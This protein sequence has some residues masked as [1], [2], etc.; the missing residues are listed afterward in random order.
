MNFLD[1]YFKY[2]IGTEISGLTHELNVFYV[3]KLCEK[4]DRNIIVLTSSLFEANKIYDSLVKIH[5]N[6]LLFPMDDFLSSMIVASSPELKYKRLETLDK[7]KSDKK[8]IIVTNLMGYLKYLPSANIKN[9]IDIKQNDVIKRDILAEEINKLGYHRES[10][11]TMSGEYAVRGFILDLYPIDYEHPIRI[12]FDGNIIDNIKYFNENTQMSTEET[13][14]IKIKAIDEMPSDDKNSLFDYAKNPLVVYVDKSQIE[15]TYTHLYDDIIEYK[16][17]KDIKEDLMY[18]LDDIKDNDKIFINLFSTDGI[19]LK[20]QSIINY[21]ENFL[22]LE[23]D[24]N[25]WIKEGKIVYFYLSNNNEK[26]QLLKIIPSAHIIMKELEHGFILDKYVIISENDIE[27]V[28]VTHG[29]YKNNF[30]VGKKIKD[31]NQLEKGD[32]VVHI[33]HG[34]GIYQGITTLSVRGVQ[35]DFLTIYYEGTDKI[36]VPVEKIDLI[37]KYTCKDGVKPKLNK[38]GSTNW[39]KTKKYISEKVKDISRE[40]ILLYKKRLELKKKPYKDY[41]EEE[42][43]ASEFKYKLT[44][45]QKK[46][47]VEIN[48]DLKKDNPMDRLLCGDV[49]FGKT[50]VAMRAM[51]KAV[52]NNEQ[53]L[54]LCPTTILSKQQYNVAKE[55]FKNWPIEIALLNRHVSARETHRILEDL[56]KGKI[57]IL[58]GTHRILSDDI[59]CKNLGMLVV[60]EEQRFGV[61]HKEKIKTMKSD[62]N[63]LTLSATPIPRTLKMAMSGLR[64]LSVIDTPPVNRYPV[65]TYVAVEDDF[66][67][68]DAIYKELARKG[69]IFILYNRVETIEKYMN[70][71]HEL[72]PDAKINFAHGKMEKDELDNI[73]TSFINNEF[74]ILICTTI[75]ESGIDIPNVNTLII[76]DADNFGLSQLYQIRGRVGRSNK[77]AY[78]YLMY[79]KNKM[80][81]D[82]AIKRLNTIKEFTELGSGYRIAMRDLSL[83]GA[84][85]IFGASQAGFVDSVGISLY[86]KM[87]EDE[88]KRQQGEFAPEEDKETQALINVSTHISDTYVTDEDIKIEIHQ[89]INEIDSYEKMLE[90]KNELED[91]FGKVT[92]DML[93]YMYEE[94]FEKLAKKY[95]IKQVVQTDRSIEI[96]LPE[97]V[98]SNIKGDKL[99]IEAMNLSRS[100]NIK[101]VNKKISIL[102]YTKDLPKHFIFYIVTLLEKIL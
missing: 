63:V 64:D 61:T 3:Q 87:I 48:N 62:V 28:K 74:D 47:V 37:Y 82:I 57:D 6:T 96:T 34:I 15:A 25:K 16:E 50:E 58:F 101:Y 80:L 19:D 94:W 56:K 17:A 71:I 55:R 69:Q 81:N 99:L 43:F 46:A 54:Y 89:K 8:Y 13:N 88:I 5:D 29:V 52:L 44:P 4:Y 75:I 59:V 65:Q 31:F 10:L 20:A 30:H 92:A 100:F 86:M 40:L 84:G 73:M 60:D 66:L 70:H 85:D 1:E 72:V 83:R 18:S 95:N 42:V 2:E 91:R 78:A 41:P 9:Y 98:S 14:K 36:Y 7:L 38:L 11:V 97:D 102:L 49:G 35:K 22:K 21:K 39:E 27:D 33:S 51:F 12:E 67:I 23:S 93:V 53:V 90:I 32:Y 45:D 26:K 76:H 79:E 77:I 68:K 24:Y